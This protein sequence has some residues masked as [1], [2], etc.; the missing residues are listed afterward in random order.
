MRHF[1]LFIFLTGFYF[2]STGTAQYPDKIIYKG[3]TFSLH[4]NP[5]EF[6]FDK[7][8]DKRPKTEIMSTALWRGYVA[9]FEI[10]ENKL[11]LKDIQIQISTND[12]NYGLG[13]KSVIDEVFPD[14]SELK[15]NWFT[16]LLILPYGKRINYVHMGYGSTYRK[17]YI[18]EIYEGNFIQDRQFNHGQFKSFK[19]KQFQ[20]FKKT[21]EYRNL[22]Q[23]LKKD[24]SYTQEFI[25]SFIRDFVTNY[26]SKI[27]TKD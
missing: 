10:S 25:D 23:S 5:L 6:Y 24:E 8:P 26:T 20:E 15:I 27:M 21:D 7:N 11:L 4:T 18:I 22:V 3:K 12:N 14:K 13:W 1:L 9:T 2:T 16:G 19:E 17:Y